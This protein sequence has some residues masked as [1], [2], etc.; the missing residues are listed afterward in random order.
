MQLVLQVDEGVVSG[1]VEGDSPQDSSNDVRSDL[2]NTG[3]QDKLLDLFDWGETVARSRH[4]PLEHQEGSDQ[5]L[6]TQQVISKYGNS[7][8]VE[9]F[10]F[11]SNLLAPI[12]IL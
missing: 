11:K 1:L 5:P 10:Q 8:I 6:Q 4:F 3:V 9:L 12:S 2:E 7:K